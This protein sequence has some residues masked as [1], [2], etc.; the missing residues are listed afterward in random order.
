MRE[1]RRKDRLISQDE[2]MEIL[3]NG[4]YGILATADSNGQPY[5]VPLSYAVEDN[6]IFY[7]S[8]NAGGSKHDNIMKNEKVSFTVV[9]KTRVEPEK[10]GTLYESVIVTGKASLVQDDEERLQAFQALIRKYS[11]EFLEEGE[12]YIKSAGSATMVVR[13]TIESISGKAKS[14]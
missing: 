14:K 1:M 13:V 4:E 2:A 7:H 12:K 11:P 3:K 6:T 8:T 10:F 5:G 9:G